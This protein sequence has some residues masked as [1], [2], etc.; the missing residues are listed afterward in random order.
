MLLIGLEKGWPMLM[1]AIFFLLAAA[2]FF[3]KEEKRQKFFF[4]ASGGIAFLMI[5]RASSLAGILYWFWSQA[6]PQKFLLPPYQPITY[7][8]GYA[9]T[10]FFFSLVLTLGSTGMIFRI[11]WTLDRLRP[12][13]F[14]KGDLLL[15]ACCLLLVRWPLALVYTGAVLAFPLL[16]SLV[17]WYIMKEKREIVLSPYFLIA[18]APFLFF[19][20]W[21]IQLFQLEA[22]QM[23]F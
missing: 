20:E 12:G 18:A 1:G 2:Y 23:P 8:L 11:F 4:Y 14:Q 13:R 7:F 21:G 15:F 19:P 9:F 10:H 3:A 17:S 22:L 5:L 6:P 16:S